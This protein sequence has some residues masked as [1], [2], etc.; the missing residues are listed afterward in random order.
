MTAFP[1]NTVTGTTTPEKLGRTLVHEHLLIGY[2][3]WEADALR[4]GPSRDEMFSRCVDRIEEMKGHGI[5]AMLDPCPNDLGRDVE[6]MAKVAQKT[7]FQIICATGLYK[8]SEGGKPHWHFRGVFARLW[9]T[10]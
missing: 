4:P 2:P 3:G 1:I 6:F 5:T 10:L 7:N 9:C 8:Q